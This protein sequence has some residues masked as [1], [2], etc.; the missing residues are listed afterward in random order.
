MRGGGDGWLP[1]NN[2]L[3][4]SAPLAEQQTGVQPPDLDVM[5]VVRHTV[6]AVISWRPACIAPLGDSYVPPAPPTAGGV[7]YELRYHDTQRSQ[8]VVTLALSTTIAFIDNLLPN[9]LYKY[10][11]TV[12]SHNTFLPSWS[13]EGLLNTAVNT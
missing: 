12:L 2:S 10:H 7:R 1:A 8:D 9:R 3:L 11:I 13:V 5:V 4:V 6:S